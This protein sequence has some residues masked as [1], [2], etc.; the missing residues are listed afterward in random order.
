MISQERLKQVLYYHPESGDF[1]WLE[2]TSIRTRIGDQAGCVLT[3][4]G[5]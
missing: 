1:V 5:T 2:K 3:L 4:V